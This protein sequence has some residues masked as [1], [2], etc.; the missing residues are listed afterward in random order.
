MCR[1][2]CKYKNIVTSGLGEDDGR[3]FCKVVI[4]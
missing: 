4:R 3:W 1:Q 2:Y